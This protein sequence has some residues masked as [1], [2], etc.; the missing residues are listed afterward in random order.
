MPKK[1]ITPTPE[2]ASAA[3]DRILREPEVRQLTGIHSKSSLV[4]AVK[5]G[6]FPPPLRLTERSIGWKLSTV[7][8]WIE[9][10]P[11]CK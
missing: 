4:R 7:T 9:S 1:T 8:A 5:S 2:S 3:I 11:S 10:R 6:H